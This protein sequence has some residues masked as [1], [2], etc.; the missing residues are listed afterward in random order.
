MRVGACLL[1]L[2]CNGLHSR[3][4]ASM[5]RKQAQP[6]FDLRRDLT[7]AGKATS[8]DVPPGAQSEVNY[9]I[10]LRSRCVVAEPAV[11]LVGT[12]RLADGEGMTVQAPYVL[13]RIVLQPPHNGG[14]RQG[15]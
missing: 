14:M 10:P 6:F 11:C 8:S 5:W 12:R 2:C 1:G 3:P 15:K 4:N 7:C 9:L 13:R